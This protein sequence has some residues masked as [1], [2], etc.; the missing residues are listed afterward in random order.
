MPFYIIYWNTFSWTPAI[1]CKKS[2]YFEASMMERPCAGIFG[3]IS[4][5]KPNLPEIPAKAT[6]SE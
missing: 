4:P 5:A 1:P 6:A 2:G 3:T